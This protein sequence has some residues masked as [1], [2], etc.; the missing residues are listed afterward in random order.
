MSILV[1]TILDIGTLIFL[2]LLVL[3]VIGG[4]VILLNDGL[5]DDD[6][7]DLNSTH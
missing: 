3:T 1:S 7:N 4:A 5:D 2:G 6:W